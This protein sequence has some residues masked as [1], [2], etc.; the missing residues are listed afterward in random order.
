MLDVSELVEVALGRAAP[1]EAAAR[2]SARY[3]PP[4]AAPAVVVWNVC[5]HCC[6]RC[7]HCYASATLNPSPYDLTTEE[8]RALIE[9]L[10]A[11]GVHVL[12]LSGG[13]PL[14]R[15]DI[16][17]LAAHARAVGLRPVVSTSGVPL[18][19]RMA[20]A[21]AAAGVGYVGVSLDGLPPFNDSYRGMVGAFDRAAAGLACASSAGMRV[22]VR[23]T[24]T[25]RNTAHV[26][27]LIAW[28]V[29]CGVNRFYLSHLLYAGRG[30]RMAGEDLRPEESRALLA[31]VFETAERLILHDAAIRLVTGGNDSDGPCL[32]TWIE[33]RHGREAAGRVE[34][35]LRRRGGN[36]AGEGILA[37]D[38][39][40]RV[41][42]DQFF[43]ACVLG[44]VRRQTFAEVLGHPLLEALRHR[45]VLLQGRCGACAYASICR[46]SHRE[47][48]LARSGSLWGPDPACVMTDSEIG[49]SFEPVTAS[50]RRTRQEAS[51]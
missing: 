48:A 18:D 22:G 28:A 49:A 41:H 23:M 40:G 44:D 38:H 14:L 19:A 12:I 20:A 21:L 7:P 36:S 13:E 37:I 8:G 46:G 26:A 42:P 9:R 50:L 29:A 10:A 34:A 43:T 3:A 47:R 1:E 2:A 30:F 25:R 35:V 16:V 24:V 33:A 51:A 45:E 31:E 5:R 4:S 17:A 11:A 15:H 6:L 27:P 39:R 32:L